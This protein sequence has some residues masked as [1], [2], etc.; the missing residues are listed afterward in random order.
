MVV[1]ACAAHFA[2]RS[3][4][5]TS[6][7]AAVKLARGSPQDVHTPDLPIVNRPV[8]VSLNLLTLSSRVFNGMPQSELKE[9]AVCRKTKFFGIKQELFICLQ[10]CNNH[11]WPD[12]TQ[13]A[14][15]ATSV[16]LSF[17]LLDIVFI[18]LLN[19]KGWNL[20]FYL[21][22]SADPSIVAALT[23]G[24]KPAKTIWLAATLS[25]DMAPGNE[26]CL[27]VRLC[28]GLEIRLRWAKG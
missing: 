26:Q 7:T 22:P 9:V 8:C 6:F 16:I 20:W 23:V 3:L 17:L 10:Q 13:V 28:V 2:H 21:K 27:E 14:L 11:F 24:R 12:W 25:S 4:R 15:Y 5:K 19:T 18:Q 1:C